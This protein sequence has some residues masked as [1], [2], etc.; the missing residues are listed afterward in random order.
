MK[1]KDIIEILEQLAP[2][3]LA[4]E[5]DNTGL[6]VG[7]PE[8]EFTGVYVALDAVPETVEAAIK[9]GCSLLVTHHPLLFSPVSN[10]TDDTVNGRMILSM[11]RAG[12]SCYSMH[13]SYDKTVGGMADA[14]AKRINMTDCRPLEEAQEDGSGIGRAGLL[15][16][17][18][19]VTVRDM[20]KIV[21]DAFGLSTAAIY[22]KNENAPVCR[23]AILPG[24]GTAEWALALGAGADVYI[25]GDMN[26]HTAMDAVNAGL[27]VIDAGHDGIEH[28]FIE[29]IAELLSN[30]IH[31][32][33]L[34]YTQKWVS[35]AQYI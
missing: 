11:I 33:D 18:N 35:I 31:N 20:A 15:C 3:S 4:C 27:A 10:I 5:W 12:L 32:N 29:E 34:I 6:Q 13:T 9:A 23:A 19:R 30:N 17:N 1:N 22:T 2:K 7:S 24:S 16:F 21:R 14:A 28:I 25:T 8:D 26:Y